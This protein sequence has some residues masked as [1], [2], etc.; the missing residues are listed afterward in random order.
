MEDVFLENKSTQACN[1]PRYF[2]V[3]LKLFLC[4][5]H[6]GPVVYIYIYIFFFLTEKI[7]TQSFLGKNLGSFPPKMEQFNAL[8]EDIESIGQPLGN[9]DCQVYGLMLS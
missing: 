8:R 7:L 5:E 6:P 4:L 1:L 2:P 3:G 9:R